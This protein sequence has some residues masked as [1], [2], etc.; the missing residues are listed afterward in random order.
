VSIWIIAVG[1]FGTA[2]ALTGK[3][4]PWDIDIV[5]FTGAF[6][7]ASAMA[8]ALALLLAGKNR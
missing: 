2:Y 1:F 3:R 5:N 6:A 8:G 7:V 4:Q